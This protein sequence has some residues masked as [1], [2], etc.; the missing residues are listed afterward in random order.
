M[1]SDAV[2][3]IQRDLKIVSARE[4]ERTSTSRRQQRL[5]TIRREFIV[6]VKSDG[7]HYI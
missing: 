2:R 5:R 3:V 4:I 1:H 7:D 6:D